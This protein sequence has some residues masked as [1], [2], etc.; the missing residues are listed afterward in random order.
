MSVS[1]YIDAAAVAR[2]LLDGADVSYPTYGNR[3]SETR[4]LELPDGRV[5]ALSVVYDEDSGIGEWI[6]R[7]GRRESH[8]DDIFGTFT[9][10]APCRDTGR[11][12]PRPD[13]F[14]GAA[15]VFVRYGQGCDRLDGAVWWQPP[16]DVLEQSNAREAV[17]SLVRTIDS[18]LSGDWYHVGFIVTI[19]EDGEEVGSASLFGIEWGL[20]DADG[21]HADY[22]RETV[23]E[24]L[25]ESGIGR[26]STAAVARWARDP[27][28]AVARRLSGE[29]PE[30]EEAPA[31]HATLRDLLA[32]WRA[33]VEPAGDWDTYGESLAN[34]IESDYSRAIGR[35]TLPADRHHEDCDYRNSS[36]AKETAELFG[37]DVAE[38][39]EIYP[40]NLRCEEEEA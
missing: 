24:L 6:G 37:V 16:A 33:T 2:E 5:A 26:A 38:N 19:T 28:E 36:A 29:D 20:D 11:P 7:D 9:H 8:H 32:W 14:T 21:T 25:E 23:A 34:R 13:G 18:Y 27:L 3:E 35:P 10:R 39:S 15:R 40:C 30:D 17:E 4:R 31:Y 22:L 1:S 12:S